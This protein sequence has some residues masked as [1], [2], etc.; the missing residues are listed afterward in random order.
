MAE[1]DQV[2][3]NLFSRDSSLQ[4]LALQR[5]SAW[6]DRCP[7]VSSVEIDCT[8]DLVRC[9]V[10]DRSG[11]LNKK[12]MAMMYEMALVRFVSLITE[13]KK[14]RKPRTMKTG[15]KKLNIPE[16][17]VDV[18]H[19]QVHRKT[20]PSLKSLLQGC[21]YWAKYKETDL[22]RQE[23]GILNRIRK[24]A[25]KFS[26]LFI[27]VLLEDG[28]LVPTVEQLEE[29]CCDTSSSASLSPDFLK[30]FCA[31]GCPCSRWSAH[32][33]LFKSSSRSSS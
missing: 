12:E 25:M 11:P 7:K 20:P 30:G 29:L 22:K 3:H 26:N 28:F 1:W 27:D 18:R 21:E 15:A 31:F 9:Q 16:W 14:R 13:G 4:K 19:R 10:R 32:H 2:R 8:A 24:F 5:I 33:H 17:L 6:R 23:G